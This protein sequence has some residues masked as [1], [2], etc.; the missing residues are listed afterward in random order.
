MFRTHPNS[1]QLRDYGTVT[2][3]EQLIEVSLD[4][5][6][7][8][9]DKYI[10]TPLSSKRLLSVNDM[11]KIIQVTVDDIV[12]SEEI[13]GLNNQSMK[14]AITIVHQ[15]IQDA[16]RPSVSVSQM[17]R[18]VTG[19]IEQLITHYHRSARTKDTLFK[20]LEEEDMVA[21]IHRIAS[22]P[23]EDDMRRGTDRPETGCFSWFW[24][25]FR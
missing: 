1:Q 13:N 3:S 15:S 20:L 6:N 4:E 23:R 7:S 25:M 24:N 5:P 18:L 9:I 22:H 21:F 16:V 2:C 14:F 10:P 12:C 17:E 19:T 11:R 8:L